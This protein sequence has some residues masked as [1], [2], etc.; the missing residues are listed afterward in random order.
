VHVP[1]QVGVGFAMLCPLRGA[2]HAA[3]ERHV[4]TIVAKAMLVA[5]PVV[6][7]IPAATPMRPSPPGTLPPNARV[8]V[9]PIRLDA[10]LSAVTTALGS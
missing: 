10:L 3:I 2:S 7:S 5:G 8:L 9:N 4:A 1:R 6:C